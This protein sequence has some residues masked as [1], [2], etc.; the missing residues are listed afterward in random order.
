MREQLR[1]KDDDEDSLQV[2]LIHRACELN[3]VKSKEQ[4]Q[5]GVVEQALLML[6]DYT[7]RI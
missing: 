2:L 6:D 4:E 1:R 7:Y 5:V 3:G